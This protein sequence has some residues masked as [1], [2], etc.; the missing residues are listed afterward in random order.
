MVQLQ[1]KVAITQ[2]ALNNSV[3]QKEKVAEE[4]LMSLKVNNL[5][6]AV[7]KMK[8]KILQGAFYQIKDQSKE[9]KVQLEKAELFKQFKEQMAMFKTSY[10]DLR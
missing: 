5:T 4:K 10:E 7:D 6:S 1:K 3:N 2:I 8:I 9:R